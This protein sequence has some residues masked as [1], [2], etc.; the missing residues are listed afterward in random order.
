MRRFWIEVSVAADAAGYGVYLD[1]KP[2]RLPGGA[3]LAV[4]HRPLAAAIAGEWRAANATVIPDDLPLT[5]L[6]GAAI[7][8]VAPDPGALRRNLLAYGE[9]DLLCYRA[10][11]PAGL[12]ARQHDEW[13]PWLDWAAAHYG[14][15]LM[16]T[17]GIIAVTQPAATMQALADA[18]AA[19]DNWAL[20]G[21][22]VAVPALG[23]LVLGLAAV[24]G[25]I[26]AA[27]A[28]AL[29]RLDESWQEQSW[30]IDAEAALRRD[31]VARDI[32]SAVEFVTLTRA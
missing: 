2:V 18:L 20:A 15:R 31:A 9:T 26:D 24:S 13:Q 4:A 27:A 22:G 7:E 14:A 17:H 16:V 6:A 8:R 21:L 3:A 10:D 11:A 28:H 19:Q 25:A 5:R 12:A 23:S 30:G 1:G 32:A 29:A